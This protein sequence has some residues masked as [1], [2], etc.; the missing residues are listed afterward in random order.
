MANRVTQTR[1]DGEQRSKY[2]ARTRDQGMR[3][4][5]KH[6]IEVDV[7]MVALTSGVDDQVL[8]EKA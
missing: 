8:C 5:R 6:S 2:R 1:D 3:Y 4:V 7:W